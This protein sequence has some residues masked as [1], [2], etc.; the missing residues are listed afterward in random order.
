MLAPEVGIGWIRRELT[1]GAGRGEV[2]VGGELGVL[3]EE[4]DENGGLDLARVPTDGPMVGTIETAG[5][6]RGLVVHTTLDPTRQPFLND[7]RIDGTAVLPG[8]MGIEAFAEVARLL[9]PDWHVAAVEDVDFLAPVK[10]YRD[11]PRTLTIRATLSPDGADIVAA[12]VLEA[13]RNLPGSDEPQRTTHFAGSVRLSAKAPEPE[14]AETVTEPASTVPAERVYDLYFHGP[15]YQV[16]AASWPCEGGYA[17]RLADPLP[18]NHVPAQTPTYV[19]PRLIELCFQTAGLDEAAR[20]GRLA[21]PQ[22]VD[23]VRV[24]HKPARVEAPVYVGAVGTD[25]HADCT[26]RDANGDVLVAV[27]GYRTS[28]LAPVPDEVREHLRPTVMR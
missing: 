11:E 9:I 21:L 14:H 18:D 8:V 19:V 27:E 28:P 26:V 17:A 25:G 7:H 2:V 13:E 22:H 23:R 3:V 12:C 10:F 1:S 4:F 24:P 15:A 20:A 16:V 5:I 6:Y